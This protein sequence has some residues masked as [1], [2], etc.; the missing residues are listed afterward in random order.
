MSIALT[1]S[2]TRPSANEARL[3]S[4]TANVELKYAQAIYEV[5]YVEA[6]EW[7]ATRKVLVE[8]SN[9]PIVSTRTFNSLVQQVP[10]A[11]DLKLALEQWSI[12]N[13]IFSGVAS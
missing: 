2:E 13:G 7:R 1:T 11:R 10:E 9:D 4:F 8:W 5:G 12:T 6:G 3:I